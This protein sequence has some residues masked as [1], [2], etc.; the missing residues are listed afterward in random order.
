MAKPFA[1]ATAQEIR[2]GRS[3]ILSLSIG[4]GSGPQWKGPCRKRGPPDKLLGKVPLLGGERRKSRKGSR[5]AVSTVIRAGGSASATIRAHAPAPVMGSG[6]PPWNC[7]PSRRVHSLAEELTVCVPARTDFGDEGAV[8][9]GPYV[10]S[11]D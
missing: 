4:L 11:A 3:L 1:V 9:F 2:S 7:K 5:G 6:A 8:G 10:L